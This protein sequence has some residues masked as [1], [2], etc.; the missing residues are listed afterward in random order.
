MKRI[1]LIGTLLLAGWLGVASTS[2]AQVFIRAPFVR[3]AVGGDGGVQ[4]RAPFVNI[5]TAGDPFYPGPVHGPVYGQPPI[6]VMPPAQNGVQPAPR[7]GFQPPVPQPLPNDKPEI[8]ED[9]PQ[10]SRPA[11]VLTHEAFAKSFK[12]KAGTYEVTLLNPI[13]KQPT[14]VRFT[15]PEGTP[16]RV[17][18]TRDSIEFVYGLRQFVRI[19]F[20]RDGALITS[21]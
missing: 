8:K 9:I 10:P 3:V 15:L 4:V 21:R 19:E 14:N 1:I 18:T 5:R 11:D 16:K 2:D 20:D 7:N 17:H 6:I 13:T 12:P